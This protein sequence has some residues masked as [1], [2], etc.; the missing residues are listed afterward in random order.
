MPLVLM[1]NADADFH[2]M[3][4]SLQVSRIYKR[5]TVRPEI[6][7]LWALNGVYGGPDAMRITGMTETLDQAQAELKESWEKGTAWANLQEST[8]GLT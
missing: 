1:R 5:Q 4:G 6:Q 8:K 3:S 2:V 7:W